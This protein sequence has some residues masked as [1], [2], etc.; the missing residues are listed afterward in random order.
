VLCLY[1]EMTAPEAAAVLGISAST[2]RTHVQRAREALVAT[3]APDND[4]HNDVATL[5]PPLR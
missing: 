2:I 1:A 3:L 4:A 5:D